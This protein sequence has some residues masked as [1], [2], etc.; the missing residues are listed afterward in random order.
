MA[1]VSEIHQLGSSSTPGTTC[2]HP[3]DFLLLLLLLLLIM[4]MVASGQAPAL[5]SQ[6]KKQKMENKFGTTES[7]LAVIPA[8]DN[9]NRVFHGR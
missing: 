5:A 6:L 3:M 7:D 4:V 8:Y 1:K 2:S 9:I